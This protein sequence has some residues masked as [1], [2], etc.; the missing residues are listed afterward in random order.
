ME[1]LRRATLLV[2]F[3]LSLAALLRAQS[4]PPAPTDETKSS[5][6]SAVAPNTQPPQAQTAGQQAAEPPI[7]APPVSANAPHMSRQTRFEII[8]D[9][10]TQIVYARAAFPMGT[11]G[12]SLKDGSTTPNGPELQQVL[13][14]WGPALKPGDPAHISYVQI[15]DNHIH[16]DLNGGPVHRKKWY[17]HIQISGANS[18]VPLGPNESQP[19]PHGTYLDLYFD[20]Y[21]PEMNPQQLRALLFP[22]LDFTARNKEEAYLDTIPP[23]AKEAI[24]EHRVLVGMNTEMVVHAKGKPP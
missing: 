10:E 15:K 9:F 1:R 4:G 16:F 22:A 6:T 5:A 12:L 18:D 24:Q 14:L 17:E 19:N 3:S 13:A 7:P 20:K 2:V 11:K 8:R 23:K 21:V